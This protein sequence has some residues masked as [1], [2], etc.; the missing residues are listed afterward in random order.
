MKKVLFLSIP[1]VLEG[2]EHGK[3]VLNGSTAIA[4]MLVNSVSEFAEVTVVTDRPDRFSGYQ[5]ANILRDNPIRAQGF[6]EFWRQEFPVFGAPSAKDFSRDSLYRIF[7][8]A[9]AVDPDRLDA[10]LNETDCEV[11]VLNRQEHFFLSRHPGLKGRQLVFFT[12]D[13]HYQRKLSYEES[14]LA[15]QPLTHVEK[16]I[17][18][19]FVAEAGKLVTIS[20]GEDDHFSR[21]ATNC[22]VILFRPT[23][24]I[25]R[26]LVDLHEKN[27][28]IKYYFIGVNNFVNRQSLASALQFFSTNGRLGVDEFHVFGSVCNAAEAMA[29]HQGKSLHGHV[30]DLQHAVSGMHVL[31]APVQS[32]SGIPLKVA[33]ALNA[34]HL[35]LSSTFGAASYPEFI[36]SRIILSDGLD[37]PVFEALCALP[38]TYAPYEKYARKN[39]LAAQQIVGVA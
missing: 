21:F 13:S 9:N 38:A 25:P 24:D 12:H 5:T 16:A 3:G 39:R 6:E 30:D 27:S 8:L 18:S 35:V 4:E 31:L 29:V 32:G 15:L 17:E 28:P 11:V 33:E 14:Y 20:I 23:I 37:C 36:G 19:A 2:I 7:Q 22:D 26:Q 34:G 1:Y 10:I